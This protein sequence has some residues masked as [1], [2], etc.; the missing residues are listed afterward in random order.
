MYEY[1]VPFSKR[2]IV[3][4]LEFWMCGGSRSNQSTIAVTITITITIVITVIIMIAM[5]IMTIMITKI[6]TILN[7]LVLS[8]SSIETQNSDINMMPASRLHRSAS[9]ANCRVKPDVFKTWPGFKHQ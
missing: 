4:S 9:E 5:I 7:I 3:C 1:S 2:R 8:S 6:I